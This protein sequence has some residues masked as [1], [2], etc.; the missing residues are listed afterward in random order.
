MNK[1]KNTKQI[2]LVLPVN[3]KFND[4][5]DIF[6]QYGDLDIKATKGYLGFCESVTITYDYDK[7]YHNVVRLLENK[8]IKLSNDLLPFIT[9]YKYII[10]YDIFAMYFLIHIIF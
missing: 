3:T 10:Y 9:N 7:D 2:K 1:I 8:Q 4:V 5:M 6:R